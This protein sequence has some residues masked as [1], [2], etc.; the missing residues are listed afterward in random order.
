MDRLKKKIQ[1]KEFKNLGKAGEADR[2]IPIKMP[3]HLYSGKRSIGKTDR[4]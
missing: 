1:N 4:R 2:M 3:K